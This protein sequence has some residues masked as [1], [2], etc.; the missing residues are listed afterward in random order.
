MNDRNGTYQAMWFL[1]KDLKEEKMN[2]LEDMREISLN[3]T[4][5]I[6]DELMKEVTDRIEEI[7]QILLKVDTGFY[8]LEE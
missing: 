4:G 6:M 2:L 5:G 3:N 7:N 8:K 1:K